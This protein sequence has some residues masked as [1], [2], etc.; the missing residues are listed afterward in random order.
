MMKKVLYTFIFFYSL[1]RISPAECQIQ[2]Q[3][4]KCDIQT[5]IDIRNQSDNLTEQIIQAFLFSFDKSC[6]SN[7]EWSEASNWTLFW[8]ADEKTDTL[9]RL[10]KEYENELDIPLFLLEFEQPV[11]DDIDLKNIYLKIKGLNDDSELTGNILKSI[12][13]AADKM[14]LEVE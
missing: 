13:T 8:L 1:A 9:I 12:K 2:Q 11:S 6:M 5:I 10:F 7:V 14:D 3:I 4:M